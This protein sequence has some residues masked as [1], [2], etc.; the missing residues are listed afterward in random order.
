MEC[1]ICNQPIAF[2]RGHHPGGKRKAT[3]AVH[4]SE[5]SEALERSNGEIVRPHPGAQRRLRLE[6]EEKHRQQ[7]AP[8][9]R[10]YPMTAAASHSQ[11]MTASSSGEYQQPR[12]A[13]SDEARQA[14]STPSEQPETA[15]SRQSEG[16]ETYHRMSG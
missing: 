14:G 7:Q 10:V 16:T 11:A 3:L 2:V 6:L 12:P 4:D 13:A 15:E 1:R 5:V 9:E 8:D